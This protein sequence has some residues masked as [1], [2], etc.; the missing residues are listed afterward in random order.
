MTRKV[1]EWLVMFTGMDFVVLTVTTGK[2]RY[3]LAILSMMVIHV[4]SI[5]FVLT[6]S[7][8]SVSI[9]GWLSVIAIWVLLILTLRK[10]IMYILPKSK[11][12]T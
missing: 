2:T 3:F 5:P 8:F 10:L 12:Q 9:V 6:I 4:I 7:P 1:I 11:N